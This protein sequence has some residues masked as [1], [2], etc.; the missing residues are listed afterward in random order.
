MASLHDKIQRL[1]SERDA[2]LRAAGLSEGDAESLLLAGAGPKF[3][4][5]AVKREE[6]LV[7][8]VRRG[9]GDIQKLLT[10]L[11]KAE[12]GAERALQLASKAEGDAASAREARDRYRFKLE[13]LTGAPQPLEGSEERTVLDE[14][15]EVIANL[16]GD[17]AAAGRQMEEMR[18]RIKSFEACLAKDETI[19]SSQ[20]KKIRTITRQREALRAENIRINRWA[21]RSTSSNIRWSS[22]SNIRCYYY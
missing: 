6:A 3:D 9:R 15:I 4:P 21:P 5:E 12:S 8:E 14:K 13:E 18:G 22:S 17:V 11:E 1:Q 20:T 19:F 7:E 2:A 10:R 16:E